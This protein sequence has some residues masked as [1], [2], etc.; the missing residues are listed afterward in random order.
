MTLGLAYWRKIMAPNVVW[1]V[2][3]SALPS[4][5][6]YYRKQLK[7]LGK[8]SADGWT[9]A[10]CPFHDDQH[11]SLSVNFQH[12]GFFCFGCG[13]RG[14]DIIE[15][16]RKRYGQSFKEACQALGAWRGR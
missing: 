12:G 4:A 7:K 2:D 11:E 10:H 14:G 15:F 1:F 3:R 13:E 9:P 5:E 6:S 16:Q 8:P